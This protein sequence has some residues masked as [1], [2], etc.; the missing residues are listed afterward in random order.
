MLPLQ[1]VGEMLDALQHEMQ[2]EKGGVKL[3]V[4]QLL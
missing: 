4:K 3:V 1:T 2:D